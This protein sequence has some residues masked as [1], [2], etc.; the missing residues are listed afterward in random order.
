VLSLLL[1]TLGVSLREGFWRT[2]VITVATAIF[3]IGGISFVYET[4]LRRTLTRDVLDLVQLEE[5]LVDSGIQE[6]C[7]RSSV[8]WKEFFSHV[9][10]LRLLPV[11]PI[12]WLGDEWVH[13]LDAPLRHASTVDVF[14]PNPDGT[15]IGEA[16]SRLGRQPEDFGSEVKRILRRVESDCKNMRE[17]HPSGR[18]TI[19]TYDGAPG[20]GLT[21]ADDKAIISVPGLLSVPAAAQI[22]AMRFARGDDTMMETWI[23]EQFISLPS[24]GTYFTT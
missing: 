24:T 5:R 20:Y 1:I 9:Q 8:V 6:V 15:A 17:R 21:V 18:F 4:Y 11:D 22:I 3:S 13:V 23:N 19:L 16:A 14:L 7:K 12:A 2:L 10:S